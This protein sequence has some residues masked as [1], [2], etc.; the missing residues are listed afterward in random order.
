MVGPASSAYVLNSIYSQL[1]IPFLCTFIDARFL[2][3]AGKY[4]VILFFRG[5]KLGTG[6]ISCTTHLLKVSSTTEPIQRHIGSLVELTFNKS[7]VPRVCTV[8]P[9]SSGCVFKLYSFPTHMVSGKT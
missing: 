6:F 2:C 5:F 9:A 7:V 8:G 4:Y 1:N 3:S